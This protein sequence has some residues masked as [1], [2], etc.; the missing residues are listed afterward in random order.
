MSDFGS[1]EFVSF[2]FSTVKDVQDDKKKERKNLAEVVFTWSMN[3]IFNRNLFKKKIKKIPKTFE[4]SEDYVN[5]F[6]FPL[7]EETRADMCSAMEGFSH[8]PYIEI[9]RV[10]HEKDNSYRIEVANPVEEVNSTEIYVPKQ[11]D[12]VILSKEKPKH[13]SDLSLNG[14]SYTVALI[15]KIGEE[16][17]LSDND[18]V[19]GVSR[20]FSADVH[21]KTSRLKEPLYAVFLCNILS[22]NRIWKMLD[23]DSDYFRGN[24]IIKKVLSF[25]SVGTM[26]DSMFSSCRFL[27]NEPDKEAVHFLSKWSLNESQLKA[28]LDCDSSRENLTSS[29]KLIWG[30]PGTGKTKTISILLALMLIK[31]CRTVTCAPTNTAVVE[32]ASRLLKLAEDSS[33][34]FQSDIV[35]FG[36]KDRMRID[37]GLSKIFLENRAARLLKCCMP[38]SGI[39]HCINSMIDIFENC[40]LKYKLYLDDQKGEDDC[41]KL[42]MGDECGEVIE[43]SREV[44][45]DKSLEVMSLTEYVKTRFDSMAKDFKCFIKIF[46]DDFPR[47]LISQETLREMCDTLNLLPVMKKVLQHG[48]KSDRGLDVQLNIEV[49]TPPDISSLGNLKEVIARSNESF[50]HLVYARDLLLEKLRFLSEHLTIPYMFEQRSVEEF[51]LQHV[52]SVLCTASSSFRLHN[53]KTENSRPLEVLVVDEAAQLKESESLIPLLLP[54]IKNVVLIGDEFQLPALV[55]SKISD[56]ADFGRSLFERLSSLGYNKHLLNVQYRMHPLISQFPV[57]HF[58]DNRISDGANVTCA[59]YGRQYLKGKMYGQYSFIDVEQGKET[60]DQYGRSLR[61]PIEVAAVVHI[62]KKLFEESFDLGENINVGV[63]SPYS[64]QV[65]LIQEKLGTTYDMHERFKVKVRSIDGFQGGEE[66]IIIFS[67]VRSNNSGSVGFLSNTNRTNVAL[68]RAK[69][70]LY[71]IGN[72]TTLSK[73]ESVWQKIVSDAK[74]RDCLFK[75]EDDKELNNAIIR[76][77]I[78][79]D[80]LETHF[81]SL[82]ISGPKSKGF[83]RPSGSRAGLVFYLELIDAD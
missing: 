37:E 42:V 62:V 31:N 40:Y 17:V 11:A 65:K 20:P 64:A 56:E 13:I 55:K 50:F 12:I 81:D 75:S 77:V 1:R 39:R 76:A 47:A 15:S 83:N 34:L 58:Y 29:F 67:T 25:N 16:G 8:A 60:T 26:E 57:Y 32:V 66:D 3:D 46:L 70:C 27:Q 30:P 53:V 43:V 69:H 4:S 61:N 54:G 45:D 82:H 10:N 80:E 14:W 6:T 49:K 24:T 73:S 36:N 48:S 5:Y 52:K 2:Q 63:V 19:I 28:V 74:N 35:L 68:T 51:V 23:S 44:M 9:L 71:I 59:A 38:H 41:R 72:A 7:M 21:F 18:A 79:Q 22:Y 78:E 33:D